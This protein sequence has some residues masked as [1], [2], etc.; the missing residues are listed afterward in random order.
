MTNVRPAARGRPHQHHTP[1]RKEPAIRV[2]I[3]SHSVRLDS[4]AL[5]R[6]RRRP[7]SARLPQPRSFVVVN[8]DVSGSTIA[9]N[10]PPEFQNASECQHCAASLSMLPGYKW[11]HHC[12]HCGSTVCADC[13]PHS[14][15]LPNSQGKVRVC[16]PCFTSISMDLTHR[17]PR[18]PTASTTEH[19][20]TRRALPIQ[21]PSP[22]SGRHVHSQQ[23]T[24]SAERHMPPSPAPSIRSRHEHRHPR[25]ATSRPPPPPDP[26]EPPTSPPPRYHFTPALGSSMG[27]PPPPYEDAIRGTAQ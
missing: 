6:R 8:P 26:M 24:T 25:S 7:Q 5:D 15:Q 20:V 23:N 12:R 1:S 10:R 13:S 22:S 11:R 16:D 17:T 2:S 18:R 21:S 9:R 14:L 19:P 4:R 3:T 27:T